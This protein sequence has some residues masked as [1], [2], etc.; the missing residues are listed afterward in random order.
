MLLESAASLPELLQ[1]A[2]ALD[3][4]H[5]SPRLERIA[6]G[7]GRVVRSSRGAVLQRLIQQRVRFVED[8]DLEIW[9]SPSQTWE[10]GFGD[11]DDHA[12]LVMYLAKKSGC[13]AEFIFIL[14]DS[15]EALH[16]WCQVDGCDAETTIQANWDESPIDAVRRIGKK[17]W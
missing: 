6:S 17:T 16:V 12:R 10:L 14:N 8:G 11:C 4:Q 9:R 5:S 15:N 13:E 1:Q 2:S 7:L 3:L